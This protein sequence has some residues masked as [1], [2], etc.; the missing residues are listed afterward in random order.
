MSEIRTVMID[1]RE[2]EVED[3]SG[4]IFADLG[5]P[6]PEE[7]LAKA[8]L[9]RRIEELIRAL[10]LTQSQAAEVLGIA[11]PDVSN[12]VRGRLSGWSIE[13]LARLLTRLGQDVEI[14]V[15]PARQPENAHLWVR[16]A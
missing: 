6:E 7:R 12:I 3:G 9:S 2:V 13:R 10:G 8:L 1:G 16:V 5:L 11:Q 4:N 14:Q 15:R